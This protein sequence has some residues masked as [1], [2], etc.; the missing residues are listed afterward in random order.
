MKTHNKFSISHSH[1]AHRSVVQ[2]VEI[3]RNKRSIAITIEM[4]KN[5]STTLAGVFIFDGIIPLNMRHFGN[6]ATPF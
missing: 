3:N 4:Q 1:A 5:L 6:W 2:F